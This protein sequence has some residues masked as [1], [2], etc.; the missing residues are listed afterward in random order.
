LVESGLEESRIMKVVGLSSAILQDD[1]DP[2]N[3]INRRINIIVMNKKA[4][5]FAKNEVNSKEVSSIP[6]GKR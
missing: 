4:I 5:E 6:F 1:K 2:Q 3:P